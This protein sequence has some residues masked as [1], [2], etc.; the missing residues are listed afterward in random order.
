MRNWI[1]LILLAVGVTVG[2]LIINELTYKGPK[3]GTTKKTTSP[4]GR[5][6]FTPK[7]SVELPSFP[8]QR[9]AEAS[10]KVLPPIFNPDTKRNDSKSKARTTPG[11]PSLNQNNSGGS[12][13][14]NS[15][16]GGSRGGG[17]SSG[18]GG[19][20][21]GGGNTGASSNPITP[22]GNTSMLPA[23]DGN[24]SPTSEPSINYWLEQSDFP[25]YNLKRHNIT[26]QRFKNI[27]GRGCEK[28]EGTACPDCGG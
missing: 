18:G 6:D 22:I 21:G 7:T 2:I 24:D 4:I 8:D 17:G 5:E 10:K 9:P 13:G 23:T 27:T 26:C 25:E 28:T 20:G 16:G 11:Q 19:G 14:R 1:K 15:G 12:S 3:V